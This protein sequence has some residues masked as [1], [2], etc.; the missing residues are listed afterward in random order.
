MQI[1]K[2]IWA[3]LEALYALPSVDEVNQAKALKAQQIIRQAERGIQ[4]QE[5]HKHM[6]LHTLHAIETWNHGV[7]AK[8]AD[9]I[10]TRSFK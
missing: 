10:H 4:E 8:T 3:W 1:F 9:D 2:R 5:Y 6:A 7:I